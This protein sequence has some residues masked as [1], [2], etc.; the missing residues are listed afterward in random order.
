MKVENNITV[1]L[2]ENGNFESVD[3]KSYLVSREGKQA[4]IGTVREHVQTQ[5]KGDG[6]VKDINDI[7]R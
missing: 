6:L 7:N 4:I 5:R 3:V 2:T 1:N